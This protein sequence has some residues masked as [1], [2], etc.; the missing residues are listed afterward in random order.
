MQLPTSISPNPLPDKVTQALLDLQVA[1]I[2][3][4]YK[5]TAVDIGL[6]RKPFVETF[7]IMTPGPDVKVRLER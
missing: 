7:R 4:G 2:E 1:C 6:D 3:H 5:R